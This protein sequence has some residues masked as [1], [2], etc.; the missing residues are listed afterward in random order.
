[1][2]GIL[3]VV[4]VV[5]GAAAAPAARAQGRAQQLP[6]PPS[7]PATGPA[8]LD[9]GTSSGQRH[10]GLTLQLGEYSGFGVGLQLGSRDV[11]LRAAVGWTPLL[12]VAQDQFDSTQL[13]FYGALQVSPDLYVRLLTFQ[14]KTDLG[15]QVGYRYS[16]LL[17]HGAALGGYVQFALHRTADV[18]VAGGLMIYPDGEAHLKQEEHLASNTSF[19]FPGP[20]VNVGASLGIALFP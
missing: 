3:A 1:M 13:D 17:G 20:S 2:R 18:F 6:E 9:A 15:L 8:A 14:G 11:G 5:L 12:L 10:L 4:A 19:S 7:P 16:S